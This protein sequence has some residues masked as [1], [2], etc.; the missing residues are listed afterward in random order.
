MGASAIAAVPLIQAC[1]LPGFG[2]TVEIFGRPGSFGALAGHN[3]VP[4]GQSFAVAPVPNWGF[5]PGQSAYMSAVTRDGTVVM[6]TTPYT[7]NQLQPT[8]TTMEVGYLQPARRNFGRVVIPTSKGARAVA[9]QG[10]RYGGADIGDLQVVGS[11]SAE[12]VMFCSAAPYHGW[13]VSQH[14]QF[15][16][17]GSLSRTSG[18]GFTVSQ[19]LTADQ[20]ARQTRATAMMPAYQNAYGESVHNSRGLC[21]MALLPRSGHIVVSQYF[22]DSSIY[23]GGL[24]VIDAAGHVKATFQYPAVRYR[25]VSIRCGVREVESD[26]S[27]KYGDERFVI[28][29]DAVD[30]NNRVVRFPVQ[31]FSYNARNG[32]IRPTSLPVQASADSSRME[33]AKYGLDGT[34]YVARTRADGLVADRVAVYRKGALASRAPV[35][36]GWATNAFNTVVRP[37]QFVAGTQATT[38]VRSIAVDPVTGAILTTGMSGTMQALT[39]RV[40]QVRVHA[41]INFGLDYLTNRS[42][43]TI[44]VRKGSVDAVRRALW[45]PIPQLTTAAA[46]RS[47]PWGSVPRLDQ[48][49][50]RVD[51]SRVLGR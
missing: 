38:L 37:D 51:L 39:G 10:S 18:G 9:G 41:Q 40:G 26:P 30:P 25:G 48:W 16:S 3:K 42:T 44:G 2:P 27:S 43:H 28:V 6:A 13:K 50:V 4:T 20:M 45:V 46:D 17:F 1:E 23:E 22:G 33:T 7:D 21:E 35:H 29:C 31:E 19:R 12:R 49:L 34:L 11:G 36:A 14:G 5:G 15:P 47:Y 32:T 8:G 24:V